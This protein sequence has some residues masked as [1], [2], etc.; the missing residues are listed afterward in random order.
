MLIALFVILFALIGAPVFAVMAGTTE[1]AWLTHE[2]EALRHVR[3]LAPDVLDE[4]FAGSP[5]LVTVPLF[6]FIGYLMAESKTPERIVRA[7]NAFFGWMPGGL[8]IVCIFASSFFTT[9]TGGSAVTIV[10]I[11]AL[12]YPALL[13][14]GYPKDY[15]LGLVM[16]GGSLGL[17]LPPSLPIL[18]YSLVAG[19]DFTKAFKACLI[20]G[21]LVIL[22]LSVHA[23]YVGVKAKIPRT[24]PD[25]REMAAALWVIKWEAGIP[26]LILG[27]LFTGLT[28][29]DEVA[30]LAAAYVL[31]IEVYV[32]KDIKLSDFP[33]ITRNSMALA[34]AVLLIMAMAMSLTNYIISE[35][36]PSRIFEFVTSMGVTQTWHFLITLNIFLYIQGMF[37]DGFSSI[38]V[39]VPLLIPFA[40]KFALSPFHMA[41]MFLLNL[42][43]A[44]LSPPLGQN[45]FVSSFRF[46]KPMVHLYRIALP[47]LGVLIVGLV[48]LMT[49]PKLSTVAIEG[50]I[51]RAKERAAEFKE[52]PREAWL[53]ECVQEDRNNPLPCT[54]EEK[55]IWLVS[56]E[57]RMPGTSG[58]PEPGFDGDAD[59]PTDTDDDLF[60]DLMGE[61]DGP[62]AAGAPGGGRDRDKALNDPND[63]DALMKEL[64][65]E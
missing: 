53:M 13:Q 16:T 62:G 32:Y 56:G 63:E 1:L 40:A 5:I 7:S 44:Y 27:G 21:F 43:I 48:M 34:G 46:N 57:V 29:I 18:V 58:E 28:G 50:D 55:K 54:E 20:P 45:L 51:Q 10:A 61:P 64:L 37:M 23:A 39:A 17:L 4:R 59:E 8:A 36:I 19:I 22:L 24:A 41:M 38:L 33:R 49:I 11:G 30:A 14:R 47:F 12:L 42:E 31:I 26:V 35:Q 52:P 6:T 15:S 2:N 60:K 3:F 9:L 65:G 25:P